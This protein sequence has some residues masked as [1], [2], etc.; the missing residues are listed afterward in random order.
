M[1]QE[2]CPSQSSSVPQRRNEVIHG[3]HI[4]HKDKDALCQANISAGDVT[5]EEYAPST[6]ESEGSSGGR[7]ASAGDALNIPYMKHFHYLKQ[8]FPDLKDCDI[9]ESI[10]KFGLDRARCEEELLLRAQSYLSGYYGP[11]GRT[12]CMS[13]RSS[14]TATHGASHTIPNTP[15][16]S[17]YASFSSQAPPPASSMASSRSMPKLSSLNAPSN[18]TGDIGSVIPP[19]RSPRTPVAAPSLV[20]S[21]TFSPT[22]TPCF[23]TTAGPAQFT[24]SSPTMSRKNDYENHTLCSSSTLLNGACMSQVSSSQGGSFHTTT[25]K[26]FV[27]PAHLN[28]NDPF[29]RQYSTSSETITEESSLMGSNFPSPAPTLT[30]SSPQSPLVSPPRNHHVEMPHLRQRIEDLFIPQTGQNQLNFPN[31][32]PFQLNWEQK[33]N[34]NFNIKAV[35]NQ[36]CSTQGPNVQLYPFSMQNIN[37][38]PQGLPAQFGN[39]NVSPSRDFNRVISS[40]GQGAEF[41]SP[42]DKPEAPIQPFDTSDLRRHGPS[43]H[44]RF[45]PVRIAP[46]PPVITNV[47]PARQNAR[48][49][50]LQLNSVSPP[51]SSV[52]PLPQTSSPA[53]AAL[54][55]DPSPGKINNRKGLLA[56]QRARQQKMLSVLQEGTKNRSD[57]QQEI[58]LLTQA[59]E[60]CKQRG[61]LEVNESSRLIL[62][63]QEENRRLQSECDQLEGEILQTG[64]APDLL[65]TVYVPPSSREGTGSS[66]SSPSSPLPARPHNFNRGLSVGRGVEGSPRLTPTRV[67]PPPPVSSTYQAPTSALHPPSSGHYELASEASTAEGRAGAGAVRWSCGRCTYDNHPDMTS[68]EICGAIRMPP[69]PQTPIGGYHRPTLV[70]ELS[71]RAD[72]L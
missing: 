20:S 50:R 5:V 16:L 23:A 65:E 70:S 64:E 57:L 26:H 2:H 60:E 11:W 13:S 43:L 62:D 38:C 35:S 68:C 63:I 25:T 51:S 53:G 14:P 32:N 40:T 54:P 22:L 55:C 41:S 27:V 31:S 71:S 59:L 8:K 72:P 39:V 3:R 42:G 28:P 7:R 15:N 4:S 44:G 52:P 18:F 47:T 34:Q 10:Q 67:A 66:V 56:D 58:S 1:D 12:A 21:S 45:E 37:N 48:P 29:F 46:P 36:H 33:N 24:P 17:P 6:S 49:G 30:L 61:D 9:N 69:S 19:S